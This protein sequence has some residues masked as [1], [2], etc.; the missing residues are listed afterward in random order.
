[1]VEAEVK[2]IFAKSLEFML[3]RILKVLENEGYRKGKKVE[4]QDQNFPSK[5]PATEIWRR[6]VYTSL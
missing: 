3:F 2:P 1:V 6:V 4:E 5:I